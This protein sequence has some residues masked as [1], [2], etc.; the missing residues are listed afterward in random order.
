MIYIKLM[1][2]LGNQM[3]QYA[4]GRAAAQRLG[5]RYALNHFNSLHYFDLYPKEL[6]K[7]TL[8]KNAYKLTSR[9]VDRPTYLWD[10][11]WVSSEEILAKTHSGAT[12]CGYFQGESFFPGF[13]NDLQHAFSIRS[14]YVN[15]F[16]KKWGQLFQDHRVLVLHIRR[17]DYL[18]LNV[19]ELGSPNL[20]LPDSYFY[21]CLDSVDDLDQYKIVAVS[22]DKTY[23]SKLLERWPEA[24][25]S[26]GTEIEDFQLVMHADAAIISNSTFAWWAAYLNRKTSFKVYGPKYWLG[27]KVAKEFPTGVTDMPWN[28]VEVPKQ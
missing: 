27:F 1:G 26:A 19:P 23:A 28:W 6:V 25:I 3:F 18:K 14:S 10:D 4:F 5:T 16:Q 7:N 24:I 13:K 11:A 20:S 12:Y 9:W 15:D 21:R 22:D 17:G 8:M 2:G